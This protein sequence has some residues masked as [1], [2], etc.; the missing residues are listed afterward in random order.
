[1]DLEYH[2]ALNSQ[3]N[4][5]SDELCISLAT[6]NFETRSVSFCAAKNNL[7]FISSKGVLIIESGNY[8]LGSGK[9]DLSDS[10]HEL[11]FEK[12]DV[13]FM[14]STGFA[15]E[16]KIKKVIESMSDTS[17]DSIAERLKR[18]AEKSASIKQDLAFIGIEF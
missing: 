4:S 10:E 7:I 6:L 16:I 12:G 9:T 5:I 13:M 3:S 11:T 17:L 14:F 15:N 2:K 1:M 18:E 8:S